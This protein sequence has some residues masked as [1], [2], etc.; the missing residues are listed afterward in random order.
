MAV[1]GVDGIEDAEY[2][3]SKLCACIKKDSSISSVAMSVS[4]GCS[5]ASRA[6][7]NVSDIEPYINR[8]DAALYE[9]KHKGRDCFVVVAM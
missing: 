7:I 8:A 5:V 4:V 2:M 6:H 9:A 1:V 3:L